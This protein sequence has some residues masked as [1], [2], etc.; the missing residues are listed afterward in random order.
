MAT[1]RR[2]I[3]ASRPTGAA[4]VSNF[5]LEEAQ[6]PTL[7]PGQ[8]LVRNEWLSLRPHRRGRMTEGRS[9]AK[10]Q[11]LGEVMQGGTA[12]TVIESRNPDFKTGE[13]VV[14]Y[15]GWQECG[16]G[17][18]AGVDRGGARGSPLS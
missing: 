1:Y 18:G 15:L 5:R 13:K 6:T 4:T 3:L 14:T 2:I 8:I 11:A 17:D 10:P 12:G 9:Y 7:Q 16:V